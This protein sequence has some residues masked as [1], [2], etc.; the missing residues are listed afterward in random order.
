MLIRF[1]LLPVAFVL[2]VISLRI[3]RIYSGLLLESDAE[4]ISLLKIPI[5]CNWI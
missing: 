1:S 4:S 3:D 5:G 2:F